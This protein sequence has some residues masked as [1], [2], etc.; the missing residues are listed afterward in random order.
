[1]NAGRD[2]DKQRVVEHQDMIDEFEALTTDPDGLLGL[3][4]DKLDCDDANF[5]AKKLICGLFQV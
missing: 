1:M 5:V 2:M 4:E 3:L